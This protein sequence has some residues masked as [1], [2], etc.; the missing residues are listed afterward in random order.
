MSM[1]EVE[2][3]FFIKYNEQ[4]DMDTLPMMSRLELANYDGETK[5]LLYVAIKGLVF[6]VT[7]NWKQYGPGKS[8]NTFVGKDCT[9]LLGLNKLRL[10]SET[11]NWLTDTTWYYDDFNDKQLEIVDKW[12][13]FFKKRYKIVGVVVS[14]QPT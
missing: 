8:Y 9:R 13:L 11:R 4:I 1:F 5:K 7:P 2:D 14:Y 12:I 10:P 6:D 3:D